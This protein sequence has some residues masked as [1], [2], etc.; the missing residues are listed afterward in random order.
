MRGDYAVAVFI[1]LSGFCLMLPVVKSANLSLRGG[2]AKYFVRRARRILPAYYA[3]LAAAF[4]LPP[5]CTIILQRRLPHPLLFTWC[6]FAGVRDVVSH[7]TLTHN[8]WAS[9]GQSILPPLWSVATEFQIYIV[10]AVLLL[11]VLRH[12]GVFAAMVFAIALAIVPFTLLQPPD[13]CAIACPWMLVAFAIGMTAA[14]VADGS[15]QLAIAPMLACLALLCVPDPMFPG[16]WPIGILKSET[17]AALLAAGVI[18]SCYRQSGKTRVTL[19]HALEWA[20]FV[21]VGVI[22]YSLYLTHYIVLAFLRV[23]VLGPAHVRSMARPLCS[24]LLGV[25]LSVVFAWAFYAIFERPFLKP[26]TH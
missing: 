13:N 18:L 5:L 26:K 17:I 25:P 9:T 21:W 23:F 8:L 11:P 7:L 2:I 20:P 16:G 10:F 6:A 12:L 1:V 14:L 15:L 3:A 19:R 22:S 24:L 4:V